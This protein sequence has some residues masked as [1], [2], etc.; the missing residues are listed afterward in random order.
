MEFINNVINLIKLN[1]YMV[2]IDLK[3]A[4]FSVTIHNDHQNYLK[5]IFGNF[6]FTSLPNGYGPTMRT[7]TKISKVHL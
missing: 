1:V 7:F 4:F 3:D 6:Q 2:S 5:F